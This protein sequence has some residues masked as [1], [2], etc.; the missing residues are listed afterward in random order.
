MRVLRLS[1]QT[2]EALEQASSCHGTPRD[3]GT[4]EVR[5]KRATLKSFAVCASRCWTDGQAVEVLH[6]GRRHS[7]VVFGCSFCILMLEPLDVS[8]SNE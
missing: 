5:L 6:T 1:I 3:F 7:R 2:P 8:I 4:S